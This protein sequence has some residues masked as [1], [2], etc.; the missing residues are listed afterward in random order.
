M[1]GHR[2]AF[3]SVSRVSRFHALWLMFPGFASFSSPSRYPRSGLHAYVNFGRT[4]LLIGLAGLSPIC[5]QAQSHFWTDQDGRRYDA[6][7]INLYK[8][9]TVTFRRP[10]GR[11]FTLTMS[12]LVPSDQM[13][14]REWL[15]KQPKG[16][17]EN[18][19]PA[20]TLSPIGREFVVDEPRVM[21]V[22]PMA[23]KG[24]P[25]AYFGI[26]ITLRHDHVGALEFV[27]VY[28]YNDQHQRIPYPLPPA[29]GALMLYKDGTTAIINTADIKPGQTYT[30]IFPFFPMRDSTVRDAPNA[31]VVAGNSLQ[32]VAT[33]F[34]DGSWRDF[35]FPERDIVALDKYADY[36][37]QELYADKQPADL[38]ALA[39]VTRL[40][41]VNGDHSPERDFFRLSL[42]VLQSFPAAALSGRW[43]AF[44]KNH[45]LLHAEDLP[46]YTEPKRKD[47]FYQL[48]LA[49]RGTAELNDAV[50]PTEGTAFHSL[51]L[52]GAAWWD[53]P[54]VDSLVF[55]FGSETKKIACVFSKSGAAFADLPVPEKETFSDA[56]P[57]PEKE[58]PTRQY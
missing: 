48:L 57:A 35:D 20:N 23:G 22:R 17:G 30:I 41:P 16:T 40:Q 27:N 24:Y 50:P 39:D 25:S 15:L 43:Y 4:L 12:D 32:A 38:F 6:S 33:V 56:T 49:G 7:I 9:Q 34:P 37:G 58:I 3:G 26:P 28:F 29:N 13:V 42:R 51:Q 36:S 8:D 1:A 31:V 10:D 45:T 19:P 5:V 47:G 53:K 44:D 11:I 18:P 14:A 2:F 55:V 46:P 54:E 21:R 52:P